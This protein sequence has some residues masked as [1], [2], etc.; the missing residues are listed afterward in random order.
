MNDTFNIGLNAYE[1]I[2]VKLSILIGTTKL[3]KFDTSL[4]DIDFHIRITGL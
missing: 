3:Y 4:N 2:S 1:P